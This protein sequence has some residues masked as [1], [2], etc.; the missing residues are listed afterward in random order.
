MPWV[1]LVLAKFQLDINNTDAAALR[2]R[3]NKKQLVKRFKYRVF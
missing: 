2:K 3:N 1:S